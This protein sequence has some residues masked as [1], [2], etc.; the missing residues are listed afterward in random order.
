MSNTHPDGEIKAV[1]IPPQPDPSP[2]YLALPKTEREAVDQLVTTTQAMQNEVDKTIA[3]MGEPVFFMAGM[4]LGHDLQLRTLRRENAALL[5][6][7]T[8]LED[9]IS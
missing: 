7:L 3:I 9:R 4:I 2:E 6:R 5:R 8:D 1:D